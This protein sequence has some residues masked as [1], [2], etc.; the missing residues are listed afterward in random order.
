MRCI[1]GWNLVSLK[2][3][4][5]VGSGQNTGWIPGQNLTSLHL[6]VAVRTGVNN[7]G[8]RFSEYLHDILL[9]TYQCNIVI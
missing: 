9:S 8:S 7:L 5:T 4:A 1:P 3:E 6:N 2:L